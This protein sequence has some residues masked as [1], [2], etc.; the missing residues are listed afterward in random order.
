MLQVYIFGRGNVKPADKRYS[1]VR[2]DYALH[3]DPASFELESCGEKR[4]GCAR[5]RAS[6][7]LL[8]AAELYALLFFGAL[9]PCPLSD[10]FVL[11]KR[12]TLAGAAAAAEDIDTSKMQGKMEFVAIDQLAAYADKKVGSM[13]TTGHMLCS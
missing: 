9:M 5:Q 4:Q 10:L 7:G 1:R 13:R 3:F 6:G 8:A 11:K 12:L 2:N